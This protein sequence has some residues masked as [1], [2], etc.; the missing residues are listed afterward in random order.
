MALNIL[1]MNPL[2]TFILRILLRVLPNNS[3]N[4]TKIK[5]NVWK[6][7]RIWL[8]FLNYWPFRIWRSLCSW[9]AHKNVYAKNLARSTFFCNDTSKS[10]R[11]RVKNTGTIFSL[12]LL[13]FFHS[14]T[15]QSFLK[16]VWSSKRYKFE[17]CGFPEQATHILKPQKCRSAV[18]GF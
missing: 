4:L 11:Q 12:I 14:N 7:T 8:F 6:T 3:S 9:A 1:Y 10:C 18:F 16:E 15:R 2:K 5:F 17:K 13:I